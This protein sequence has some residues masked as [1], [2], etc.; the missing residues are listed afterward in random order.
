MVNNFLVR[1]CRCMMALVNNNVIPGVLFEQLQGVCHCHISGENEIGVLLLIFTIED[2]IG[3]VASKNTLEGLIGLH[4]NGALMN[5]I[6][7][8]FWIE[9]HC[10]KGRQI[11]LSRTG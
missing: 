8:P 3:A 4:Q 7:E 5:N 11:S 6:K 10:I 9:V 2:A 1:I